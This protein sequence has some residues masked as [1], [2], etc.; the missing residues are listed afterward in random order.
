MLLGLGLIGYPILSNL[1]ASG[2]QSAVQA[3]YTNE[4]DD[5]TDTEIESE[6]QAAQ[7]YNE[8]LQ[9]VKSTETID[10]RA[11]DDLLSLSGSAVMCTVEIPAIDVELPV[12]HGIGEDVL[13]KGA[14]H[15]PGTSLPVGG[16]S[17]HAVISAHSGLPAAR[18]FTDLDKLEEGDLFYI[19]VLGET[20]CYEVDQIVVTIPSDTE[21]IQIEKGQDYVTLLTCTPYGVNTH[22]LLVRGHRTEIPETPQAVS[23]E[24][25]QLERASTWTEKYLQ[26]IAFGVA[27]AA[28]LIGGL[29]L[30]W[31]IKK[32]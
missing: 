24:P 25:E 6:L 30:A 4:I 3:Q 7:L 29:V 23:D 15:M 11:Y 14:G 32:N 26:G 27:G 2:E 12:Y 22:R 10:L 28:L 8:A 18:L 31:K 19:H 21:A 13:Q 16:E 17:T 1:L 9:S 20:L 5:M